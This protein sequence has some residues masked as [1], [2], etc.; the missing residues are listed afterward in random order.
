MKLLDT[1]RRAA[2][3]LAQAKTRTFLTSLAIGVGAFTLTLAIAVGEGARQYAEKII[4]TNIDPAALLVAKDENIFGQNGQSSAPREYDPDAGEFNGVVIERLSEDDIAK[5]RGLP[6]VESVKPLFQI[7]PEFL[8]A[9]N[10]DDI[11][12]AP[13]YTASVEVY[14]SSRKPSVKAGTIPADGDLTEKTLILPDSYVAPFG[15]SS[16][17]AAIG[18][19][20][21]MQLRRPADIEP[22]KIEQILQTEGPEGLENIDPFETKTETFTIAAIS[23]REATTIEPTDTVRVSEADALA[24]SDYA[25]EGTDDFRKY[26]A[27]NVRVEGGEDSAKVSEVQASVTAAGYT[28]LS[29]EDAQ[30]FLFQ[31]VGVL[32]GIVAGFGV[33]A[34]ITS[35]F[36]I[37]NTQYI[38]VLERVSQIGLMKA[39]G[40]RG[41]DVGN[42]FRI[43]AALIGLLGGVIGAGSAVGLGTVANPY[44]T[45]SLQ[46]GEGTML[47]IFQPIPIIV[48]IAVL[49]LVAVI[50]GLLPARK[51]VKLDPIEALRTE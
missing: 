8:A 50:A 5:L 44:I 40:M 46:L 16:A 27:A 24:L 12:E 31:I 18:Q 21:T 11:E 2:R 29:A 26:A 34:L 47:L 28:A 36:G 49:M 45:E 1:T 22:E 37:I 32:Q 3:A 38:S 51:A 30:S 25:A 15:F 39:L 20:V 17:E 14:N 7:S 13:K 4:V 9:G 6:G 10:V 41:F 23:Q 33:L 48:L 19:E 35:V 43:E 42:L